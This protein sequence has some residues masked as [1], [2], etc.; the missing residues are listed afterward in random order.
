MRIKRE[1][2]QVVS[3]V[4]SHIQKWRDP[5]LVWDPQMFNGLRQVVL[6]QSLVWV[7][8]MFIYNRWVMRK[9]RMTPCTFSMDTKEMLT[10]NRYDLRVSYD[11]H[12]KINIPQ[13][14]TCICRLAIDVRTPSAI[15]Y[16]LC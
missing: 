7:P 16:S 2:Q 6:P 10:D 5:G 14:V 4:I 9:I 11:G 12:V 1:N 3:F 13:Y 15:L 8:K